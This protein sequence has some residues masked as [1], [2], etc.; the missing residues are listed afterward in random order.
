MDDDAKQLLREIRDLLSEAKT[1][2][3]N[4]I[5]VNRAWMEDLRGMHSHAARNSRSVKNMTAFSI[6][7]LIAI[8]GWAMFIH[9]A[10]GG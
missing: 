6:V 4:W 3:S 5:E 1:R 8:V 10:E 2:E 7:I 9:Y